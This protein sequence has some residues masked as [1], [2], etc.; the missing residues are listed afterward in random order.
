MPVGFFA[1][2]VPTC[3]LAYHHIINLSKINCPSP[4]PW[5]EVHQ[6]NNENNPIKVQHQS[7][8]ITKDHIQISEPS[9]SRSGRKLLVNSANFVP[10]L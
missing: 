1:P 4:C 8:S 3:D 5:K 9:P 2:C 6:Q 10:I 7:F